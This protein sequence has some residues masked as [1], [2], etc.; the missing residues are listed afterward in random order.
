MVILILYLTAIEA[1][2]GS[3]GM[4]WK[5]IVR[6]EVMGEVGFPSDDDNSR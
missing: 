1:W 5:E 6:V 4:E 3:V 2:A